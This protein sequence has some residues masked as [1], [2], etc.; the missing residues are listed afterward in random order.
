MPGSRLIRRV[1]VALVVVP[2]G[3]A[4]LS[5]LA[6]ELLLGCNPNPYAIGTCA[7]S[8]LLAQCLLLGELFG[9]WLAV[10]AGLFA[11][12]PLIL[13][14]WLLSVVERKRSQRVA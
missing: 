9:A 14:S 8:S 12:L 1:A 2:L 3:V 5:W 6:I 13:A 7:G 4:A 10:A 11:A